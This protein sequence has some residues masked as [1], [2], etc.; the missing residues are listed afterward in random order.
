MPGASRGQ[1]CCSLPQ[2]EMMTFVK[3]CLYWWLDLCH[4][5]EVAFQPYWLLRWYL[6]IIYEIRL[7]VSQP[8]KSLD[9]HFLCLHPPFKSQMGF[10][11]PL[12]LPT[13]SFSASVHISAIRLLN[14]FHFLTHTRGGDLFIRF[15]WLLWL[16]FSLMRWQHGP[17]TLALPAPECSLC[18]II[19]LNPAGFT[20]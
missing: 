2:W 18:C 14:I 5:A 9:V 8:E 4:Y 11:I 16:P 19:G 6:W 13:L 7:T 12:L 1:W 3:C 17:G 20:V 15:P 10:L